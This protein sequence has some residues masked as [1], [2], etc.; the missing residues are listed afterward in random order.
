MC[1]ACTRA[2][3]SYFK[4]NIITHFVTPGRDGLE[5]GHCGLCLAKDTLL[6]PYTLSMGGIS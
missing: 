5:I 3:K 6:A 1:G 2:A 4:L